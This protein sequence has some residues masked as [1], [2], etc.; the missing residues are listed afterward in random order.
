MLKG[1]GKY[2]FSSVSHGSCGLVAQFKRRHEL[3]TSEP[4][5]NAEVEISF[6]EPELRRV[7]M[8]LKIF[9]ASRALHHFLLG[10]PAPLPGAAASVIDEQLHEYKK[11]HD[12]LRMG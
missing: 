12:A 3:A 9:K 4:Q 10:R 5:Q 6:S 7:I 8:S 1:K 11:G 2:Y